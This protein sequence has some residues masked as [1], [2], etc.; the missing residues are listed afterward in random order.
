MILKSYLPEDTGDVW[1]T[2]YNTISSKLGIIQYDA[3]NTSLS[4]NDAALMLFRAYKKQ[5]FSLQDIDY[6]SFLLDTRDEFVQ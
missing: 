5:Q 6:K 2:E 3:D 4:R 1:Y